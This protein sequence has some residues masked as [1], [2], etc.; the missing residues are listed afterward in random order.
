M[1][2]GRAQVGLLED[3][4]ND[5]RDDHEE[6][7]VPLQKLA[8]AA[9]ALGEPVGEVDD[10]RELGELGRVDGRQRADLQPARRAADAD[11][12]SPGTRTSTSSPMATT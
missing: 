3:E 1:H 10:Q 12:R 5:R 6:G 7:T 8:D 2:A 4:E 9:A 11:A